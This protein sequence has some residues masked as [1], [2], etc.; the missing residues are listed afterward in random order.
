MLGPIQKFF[1]ANG[2]LLRS[3]EGAFI[4]GFAV[5][6]WQSG[7]DMTIAIPLIVAALLFSTLIIATAARL[8]RT[9]KAIAGVGLAIFFVVEGYCVFWHYHPKDASNVAGKIIVF[10][11]GI[12]ALGWLWLALAL[13]VVALFLYV[14]RAVRL[15]QASAPRIDRET[16]L[17][18]CSLLYFALLE[19]TVVML[20]QLIESAPDGNIPRNQSGDAVNDAY[21][22][23]SG[24]IRRVLGELRDS[25]RGM[26]ARGVLQTAEQ[27]AEHEL[28]LFLR[29]NPSR[30]VDVIALR[31]HFI[32]EKQRDFILPFL[33]RERAEGLQNIRN[34]RGDLIDRVNRRSP[35]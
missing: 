16:H 13:S 17:D 35:P 20:D 10:L 34:K 11:G 32:V 3:A 30:N 14:R 27:N 18:L 12:G 29:E 2:A 31:R 28:G 15:P 6:I 7:G 8:S 9:V 23:I 1:A 26:S 5:A 22:I 4:I 25:D 19:S 33:R 21:E 24:Y